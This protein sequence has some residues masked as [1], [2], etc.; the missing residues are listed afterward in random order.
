MNNHLKY[1]V[2]KI[3]FDQIFTRGRKYIPTEIS[4]P[5][6]QKTFTK[7]RN[8]CIV[9]F[10]QD[11]NTKPK[12]TVILA[13][14][15]LASA[16]LFYLEQT[17][18][19]IYH[20]LG[21]HVLA[22]DFN[23]FGET[24]F[25]DFNFQKDIEEAANW[26]KSNLRTNVIIGHGIS[27]G[28]AQMIRMAQNNSTLFSKI[29]IENCLDKSI[30]YFKIRNKKIY[31]FLTILYLFNRNQKQKNDFTKLISTIKNIDTVGFIY[32]K[33]DTLTTIEMCELL[34]KNCLVP[35]EK[36]YCNGIHLKAIEDSEKYNAFIKDFTRA[37]D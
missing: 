3:L 8:I 12:G 1:I 28:A 18:F 15:Y 20:N 23:G 37:T 5:R 32:C 36:L 19:D 29:I 31:Y 14:P 21:F 17:Y 30:H 26:A 34:M 4:N 27:F 24:K 25:I 35:Y 10:L 7:D 13:H 9:Y 11:K 16:K 2:K 33:N 22:F 6:Y